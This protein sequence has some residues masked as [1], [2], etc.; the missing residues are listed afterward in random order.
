MFKNSQFRLLRHFIAGLVLLA[1]YACASGDSHK[2]VPADLG[3]NPALIGIKG[4]WNGQIGPVDFPLQLKSAKAQVALASSDGQVLV[5]D[6]NSGATVWRTNV[7]AG[8]SAGVGFD[9][10]FAALVTHRNELIVL[11]GGKEL[12]RARLTGQVF[13][14]PLVAGE[15]VFVLAADRTISAFD[16]LTGRKLWQNQRPGE[17]LVL[18]QAGVLLAVNNTLVAGVSGRLVGLNPA[19]GSALWDVAIASPRG[20]NDIERLVD[21]LA[22]VRR[23]TEV[24]CARAF[25]AA[26]ACVDAGKGKL[27]W[28]QNANGSVGVHGDEQRIFGVESDGRVLA[29]RAGNGEQIWESDRLRFR[30]LSA[31]LALGRSIVV[32]D[33]TGLVH[34]MSREDGSLLSRLVT[35]ASPVEVTPLLVDNT[36]VV[37]TRKGGIFGFRP[38]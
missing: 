1:L 6:A 16:A 13:T 15:R 28:R 17:A 8:V 29:W 33:N 38:E 32:G 9:G 24:V 11:E 23:N 20:T 5:L 7:G 31:P 35:D 4:V 19:L 12:W 25:Q 3:A 36:L 26:V 22:G 30:Q 10:R 2:P 27:L 18:R 14:A 34:L 21:L 37:V